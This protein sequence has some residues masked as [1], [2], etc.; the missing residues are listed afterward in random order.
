MLSLILHPQFNNF[1]SGDSSNFD[2]AIN[3]GCNNGSNELHRSSNFEKARTFPQFAKALG[4][5]AYNN[6]ALSQ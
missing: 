4:D 6:V 5:N 2:R 1:R 3:L